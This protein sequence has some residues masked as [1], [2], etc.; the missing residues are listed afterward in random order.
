VDT[1]VERPETQILLERKVAASLSPSIQ[2]V[3]AEGKSMTC[4]KHLTPVNYPCVN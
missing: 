4:F 2:K 1:K 3:K